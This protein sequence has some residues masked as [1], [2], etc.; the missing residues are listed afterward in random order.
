VTLRCEL[1]LDILKLYLQT[2]YELSRSR[3]SKVQALQTDTDTQTDATEDTTTPNSQVEIITQ[4][5]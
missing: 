5:N 3:L 1:D 4:C 2:N